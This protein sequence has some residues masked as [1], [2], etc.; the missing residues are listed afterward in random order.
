MSLYLMSLLYVVA[1]ILHFV[2]PQTYLRI[3]PPSIPAPLTMVYLSG[4]AELVLGLALLVPSLRTW[5]AWGIILLLIA[6]FPANWYMA[7]SGKFT[8]IPAWILWARLPLQGVL[9]YWAYTFT[10]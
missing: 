4:V 6:V 2:R 8:N 5:A 1:G 10:K 9:I 3:M 7:T